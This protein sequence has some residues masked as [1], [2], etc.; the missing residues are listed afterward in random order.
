MKKI[1][2]L[3]QFDFDDFVKR[4]NITDISGYSIVDKNIE[5]DLTV[6]IFSEMR[7]VN[8]DNRSLVILA[9][10]FFELLINEI[11][12]K[13][14]KTY[15]LILNDNRSF[16][17]S[18]KLTILYELDIISKSEFE[19]LNILRRI[20]NDYSHKPFID[21]KIDLNKINPFGSNTYFK[22]VLFIAE[23]WNKHLENFKDLSK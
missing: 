17:Y 4:N 10:S 7:K 15:K 3:T 23:I 18:I 5:R 1:Q 20:R 13:K 14:L 9:N 11:I 12:K 22:L 19:K 2:F 6:L 21:T 8:E 16:S